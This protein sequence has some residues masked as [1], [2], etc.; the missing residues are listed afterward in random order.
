MLFLRTQRK[1]Q[2][3]IKS[4]VAFV[5]ISIRKVFYVKIT[6]NKISKENTRIIINHAVFLSK[7]ELR[8]KDA[9][10]S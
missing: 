10:Y 8:I 4:E 9:S 2:S 5:F 3:I 1:Y 6:K 7:T